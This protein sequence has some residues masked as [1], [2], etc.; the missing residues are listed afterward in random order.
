[1]PRK[2]V[3]ARTSISSWKWSSALACFAKSFSVAATLDC[4]ISAFMLRIAAPATLTASTSDFC[5]FMVDMRVSSESKLVFITVKRAIDAW[6]RTM[7]FV[8]IRISCTLP[9]FT[10]TAAA[11]LFFSIER[12]KRMISRSISWT[13]LP[14]RGGAG[15]GVK[16]GGRKSGAG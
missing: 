8:R 13:D 11:C 2:W 4:F 14:A 1:M 10:S 15:R 6:L 16:R 12:S 9:F 7:S 3:P 5:A